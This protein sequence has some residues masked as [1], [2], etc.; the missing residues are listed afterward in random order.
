MVATVLVAG[1]GSEADQTSTPKGQRGRRHTDSRVLWERGRRRR[2]VEDKLAAAADT[3]KIRASANSRLDS[4]AKIAPS[5]NIMSRATQ[6][7]VLPTH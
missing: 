3:P 7:P 5:L 2:D 4:A 1:F 6:L